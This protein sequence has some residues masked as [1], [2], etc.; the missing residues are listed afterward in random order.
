MFQPD[1][2]NRRTLLFADDDGGFADIFVRIMAQAGFEGYRVIHVSDGQQAISYFRGEGSF[3]N[4][5]RYPLAGVALL[6]IKMPKKDGFE[7]L[8][9]IRGQSPFSYMPVIMLT[10]SEE[11]WDVQKAYRL[12][13][14]SFLL[15][16]SNVH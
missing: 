1:L 7:V 11:I 9:W 8:E 6:D 2:L 16:S 13:A 10:S 14:D 15:K 12:G 4:R 3:S 5:S